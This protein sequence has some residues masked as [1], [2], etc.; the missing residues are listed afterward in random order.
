MNNDKLIKWI[1]SNVYD[2]KNKIGD[3]LFSIYPVLYDC[4]T[5]N[6]M[7]IHKS[8]TATYNWWS[9]ENKTHKIRC[10]ETFEFLIRVLSF[11]HQK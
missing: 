1:L 2:N 4:M 6:N 11:F 7:N 10:R 5:I 3:N 8:L 9:V